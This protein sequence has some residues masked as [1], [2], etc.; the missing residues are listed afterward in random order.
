MNKRERIVG[1]GPD[2]TK[3]KIFQKLGTVSDATVEELRKI[4]LDTDSNDIGTSEYDITETIDCKNTHNVL[5]SKY[6][7]IL[8]Q[9]KDSAQEMT[10]AIAIEGRVFIEAESKYS[11]WMVDK[12]TLTNT[13]SD[14]S[15]Y[16]TNVCRFRL[17]ETQAD[18]SITWHIDTNTSVM[19]RGQICL[20]ED[21]SLFEFKD[22]SGVHQLNMKVGELWFINTGWNH[23]VV[24]GKIVRKVAVFSFE[25]DNLIDPIPL[26]L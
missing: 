6:R 24:A 1:S 17:S 18:H 5:L 22:R 21:D 11:N 19:C 13:M 12:Y 16:F 4:Y 23:R 14:M 2:R 3:L 8:M 26:F 9:G 15:Q 25:F 10:S 7:Q 20:T